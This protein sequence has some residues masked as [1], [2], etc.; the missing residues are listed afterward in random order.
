MIVGA[1]LSFSVV[2]C[3]LTLQVA[4]MQGRHGFSFHRE[5]RRMSSRTTAG[6][7]DNPRPRRR[8]RTSVAPNARSVLISQRWP[9]SAVSLDSCRIEIPQHPRNTTPGTSGMSIITNKVKPFITSSK[10]SSGRRV[11]LSW[12]VKGH[13]VRNRNIKDPA[14]SSRDGGVFIFGMHITPRRA[15]THVIPTR[16]ERAGFC[17]INRSTVDRFG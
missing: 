5:N 4:D 9:C 6:T 15:S 16:P 8:V 10:K 12:E 1:C 13:Q 7:L 17:C 14:L 11:L 3:D 2:K